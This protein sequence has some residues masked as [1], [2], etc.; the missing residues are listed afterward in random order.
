MSEFVEFV[1]ECAGLYFRSVLLTQEGDVVT[2]HTHDH[3]HATYIGN[4]KVKLFIEG[5]EAGDFL[6]GRAVKVTAN[7][8]HFFVALE[9]NT[10]LTCVHIVEKAENNKNIPL[11]Q[12]R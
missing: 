11:I 5:V 10:R 2:Q 9:P 8:K 6:A 1:D 7:Q 4:G 12:Y 3:D